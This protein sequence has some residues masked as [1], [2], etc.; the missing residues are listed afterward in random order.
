MRCSVEKD[1][2]EPYFRTIWAEEVTEATGRPRVL[3]PTDSHAI[4]IKAFCGPQS[5]EAEIVS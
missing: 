3:N 4:L 1:Y 2:Y 5:L